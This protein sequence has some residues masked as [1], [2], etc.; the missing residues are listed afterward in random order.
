MEWEPGLWRALLSLEFVAL[1]AAT[2][3]ALVPALLWRRAPRRLRALP[4]LAALSFAVIWALP[5]SRRSDFLIWQELGTPPPP[6]SAPNFVLL[7]S[8]SLRGDVFDDA[9]AVRERFPVLSALRSQSLDFRQMTSGSSWT[10]PSMASLLTGRA[11]SELGA[12]EGTLPDS[13]LSFVELLRDAGYETVGISDNHLTHPRYGYAQG[14]TRYWQR[15]NCIPFAESKLSHWRL[16]GPYERWIRWCGLQYRGAERVE[17]ALASWSSRRDHERPF[18]LVI[19]YMDTHY[20]YY[21]YADHPANLSNRAQTSDFVEYSQVQL[22]ERNLPRAPFAQAS[23]D[24]AQHE[25]LWLRY[26]GSAQIVDESVGR[27][28]NWLRRDDLAA[29]T[30]VVFTADHGEEFHEHG[31]LAHGRALYQ[32]S[33]RVPF[34]LRP[35]PGTVPAAVVEAAMSQRAIPN[36]LLGIAGLSTLPELPDPLPSGPTRIGDA[37]FSELDRSGTHIL[38]GR[39]GDLKLLHAA[40]RNGRTRDE[41]YLVDADPR[42]RDD[43]VAQISELPEAVLARF[44]VEWARFLEPSL[45]PLDE[46]R[47]ELLRGLGYLR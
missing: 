21:V 26:L 42:E 25:S 23:L 29:S 5:A 11:P 20:P 46:H 27:V 14:F 32:E 45:T 15:N 31:T 28:L 12:H 41:L 35:L 7:I 34:F 39:F 30:V 16:A 36:T 18:C 13:A 22:A 9:A 4:W 40:A 33:I 38:A 17:R 6:R 8:D 47:A 43:R 3:I 2:A 24:P 37:V 1:L 44:D 19:H 10:P